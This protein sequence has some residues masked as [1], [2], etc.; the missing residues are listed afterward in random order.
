MDSVERSLFQALAASSLETCGSACWRPAVDVYRQPDGWLCKFDLAGVPREDIEVQAGG[1]RLRVSGIRRDRCL[2][3]DC[4]SWSM[5]IS[6]HSF[7][8]TVELPLDLDRCRIVCE[9]DAGLL[10]VSVQEVMP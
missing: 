2:S 3:E 4:E 10:L 6:Y 8:R 5:E 9:L 1:N 7:E